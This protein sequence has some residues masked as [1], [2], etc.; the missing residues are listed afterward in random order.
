MGIVTEAGGSAP[1]LFYWP[2]G[3]GGVKGRRNR[4]KEVWV[5][6]DRW[7]KD[8]VTAALEAGA[9]A[10]VAPP[11]MAEK[12]QALGRIPVVSD[13]GDWVPGRD[14]HCVSV[15]GPEEEH[16]A[17]AILERGGTVAVM[18]PDW[19]IIP[20]E[21]L[22]ARP[23]RLLVAVDSESR[24]ETAL[25]ILEKGVCGVILCAPDPIVLR[26][27]A[28]KVR[29]TVPTESLDIAEIVSV[30]P[31]GLGDRVC[32]D[33]SLMMQ[34]GQGALVGNSAGFLFLVQAE[35]RR[36]PYVAPRPFRINAGAVHAYIK[37]PDGRTRYLCELAAGDRILVV[38]ASG[39]AQEAVVGRCK[40]ERR[41][42]VLVDALCGNRSGSLL[43]QNAETI[44]LTDAEGGGL[45]ITQL[46]PGARVRVAL[47]VEGR[48]FGMPV[49]ETIME[50]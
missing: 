35:T 23:G 44:C 41:P 47:A 27:W 50:R 28:T 42:L 7:D 39:A 6:V 19:E 20:L 13:D 25:G 37:V 3:Q 33:T 36:N 30:R 22:V 10:V 46:Q 8:M 11:G 16:E 34:E 38:D 26:R 45:S 18:H 24:L 2:C 1:G 43:V 12:I 32:V 4:V 14:V 9:D 31:V 49:S 17:A 29:A 21:N 48:H 40:I 5:Q 15:R